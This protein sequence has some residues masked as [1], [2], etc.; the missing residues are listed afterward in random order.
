MAKKKARE[1]HVPV[2][3]V[4][5]DTGGHIE[6]I[7]RMDDA[8]TNSIDIALKKAKTAMHFRTTSE[9]VGHI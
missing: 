2:N 7:I 3:I 8:F 5:L 9:A 6:K 1:I 4:V